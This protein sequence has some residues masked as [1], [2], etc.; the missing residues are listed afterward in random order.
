[1]L[2]IAAGALEHL[3]DFNAMATVSQSPRESDSPYQT[4][5]VF[6]QVPPLE[7][8]DVFSSNLPLV[9]ATEREGAGWVRERARELGRSSAASRSS[10]GAGRP[11]R[12]SRSCARSTATATASTRSS[13]TRP[14][15]S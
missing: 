3:L 4:H 7:G 13:S 1:M 10:S 8:V 14:G 9:E 15:T 5:T 12:T 2:S 6:N 11:T